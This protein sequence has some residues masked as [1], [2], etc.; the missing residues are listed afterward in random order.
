VPRGLMSL[1][2]NELTELS[3][4]ILIGGDQDAR[5]SN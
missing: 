1:S 2:R 3:K 4:Q 5:I